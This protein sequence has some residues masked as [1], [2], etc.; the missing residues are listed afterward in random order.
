MDKDLFQYFKNKYLKRTVDLVPCSKQLNDDNV[1]GNKGNIFRKGA[2]VL[3]ATLLLASSMASKNKDGVY[4]FDGTYSDKGRMPSSSATTPE[5]NTSNIIQLGDTT[6]TIDEKKENTPFT[7]WSYNILMSSSSKVLFTENG[8]ES[9]K[10]E[11]VKQVISGAPDIV[12]FQEMTDKMNNYLSSKLTDYGVFYGKS[13]Q[14]VWGCNQAIYYNKDRFELL[15]GDKFYLSDT[16]EQESDSFGA[17]KRICV[18]AKLLDKENNSQFYV[19]NTHYTHSAINKDAR[20]KSSELINQSIAQLDAPVILLGDFNSNSSEN[21][22]SILQ[23][24]FANS[25]DIAEETIN[26]GNTYH[27][28]STTEQ[29]GKRP[30]DHIWLSTDDG[31]APQFTVASYEVQRDYVDALNLDATEDITAPSDHYAISAEVVLNDGNQGVM[32]EKETNYKNFIENGTAKDD[33]IS[34]EDLKV[35]KENNKK[36]EDM[37]TMAEDNSLEM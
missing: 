26:A 14:S 17:D 28:F 23:E 31:G 15:E 18:W 2:S 1:K 21:A 13:S 12:C 32:V 4:S 22:Y 10:G 3:M 19:Y 7:I 37:K 5:K 6:Y 24:S 9:R 34:T 33:Y 29:E 36:K 11:L 8:W 25:L 30:I 20:A 27:N 16:P 35:K